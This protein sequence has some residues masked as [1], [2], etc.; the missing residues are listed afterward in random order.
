MTSEA[1]RLGAGGAEGPKR[2]VIH[3]AGR[4]LPIGEGAN[5]KGEALVKACSQ[6]WQ[7]SFLTLFIPPLSLLSPSP[8][9]TLDLTLH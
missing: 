2:S 7:K 4:W 6:S 3:F 9:F 1:S 8:S 5:R